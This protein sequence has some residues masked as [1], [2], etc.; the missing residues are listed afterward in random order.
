MEN[1]QIIEALGQLTAPQ[2]VALTKEL[3]VKW[4][5]KATPSQG[6]PNQNQQ[7]QAPV[8]EVQ[9]EFEV[10]LT[11]FAADKKISVIKLVRDIV[12]LGLK[13]AK[14]LVEN[15]PKTLRGEIGKADADALLAKVI[16]AGGTG[17]LR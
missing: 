12:A 4:G 1:G 9:T 6:A 8:V 11:G 2:L 14:E 7:N 3:E 10:V 13:E 15:L 16:E 5:V 17:L